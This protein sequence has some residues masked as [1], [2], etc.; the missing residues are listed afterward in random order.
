MAKW[1][2]LSSSVVQKLSLYEKEIKTLLNQN[3][4]IQKCRGFGGP[5]GE[6]KTWRD[7]ER[8]MHGLALSEVIHKPR[9]RNSEFL[10]C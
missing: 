10:L 2:S 3:K 5:F 4:E 9:K 1:L 7:L 6:G 8:Q